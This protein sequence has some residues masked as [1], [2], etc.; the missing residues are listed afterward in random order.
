MAVTTKKHLK[1]RKEVKWKNLFDVKTDCFDCLQFEPTGRPR[2][3]FKLYYAKKTAPLWLNLHRDGAN[4][5]YGNLA[6]RI[7]FEDEDPAEDLQ[8]GDD[9]KKPPKTLKEGTK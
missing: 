2:V 1:K 8:P 9:N 4:T 6:K 5:A 3:Y 7:Y